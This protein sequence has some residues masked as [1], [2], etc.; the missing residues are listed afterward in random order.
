[1][2]TIRETLQERARQNRLD[3]IHAGLTRRDF[4][5]MG[6]LTAAGMLVETRGLSARALTSAGEVV[7]SPASPGTTPFVAPF[8][9]LDVA[10]PCAEAAMGAPPQAAPNSAA[11]E[12]R[13]NTHQRFEEFSE[14]EHGGQ[15]YCMHERQGLQDF[16][17]E[18][19]PQTIWGFGELLPDG[20]VRAPRFPGPVYH[21]RYGVP[22]CVRMFNDLPPLAAHTG[23]GRPETTT[24]LHNGHTAP[25]SDGNPL[26]YF[27]PGRWY[28]QHY[29]N[30]FAGY[31][32]YG[33][34]AETGLRGDRRETLGTLWYHDHRFDFTAQNTYRGL[35]GMYLLF[36]PNDTGDEQDPR[37]GAFRLPAGGFDIPMV[38][39]D[40]AFDGDGQMYFDLFNT[41]GILGDKFCVNGVIQPVLQVHPRKYRF[42]I[43]NGG[44]SR[45]YSLFLTD[46]DSPRTVHRF[47]Q[48]AN[49]GNLLPAPIEVSRITL[50]VAERMDIVV[51]FSK[52]AG[53]TLY[54]E[55]R[56]AMKDGRKPDDDLLRAGGGNLL[57]KIEVVLPEV[58]DPSVVPETFFDLP[59]LD[60]S[61][62][63][64][65]RTFRFDR[66]NGAWA[67]NGRFFDPQRIDAAPKRGT[68]EIWVIRNSS[69]GWQ[70]PIHI[71]HEEFQILSRNGRTPPAFERGRK[72]VVR[73]GFNEE[74]RFLIRFRDWTGRYPLHCHNT[75]HEDHSMMML[76]EIQA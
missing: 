61:G 20:S 76:W 58:P 48:I 32:T 28:D 68:S 74:I 1:M 70:H 23:F 46:L 42:R 62:V 38:L 11:G 24:H 55:N 59:P 50:S 40:K 16:H 69:G 22:V 27:G 21:A 37:P 6:L 31:D 26:D 51:D 57:M 35:V 73:L 39:S 29:A 18:L 43:L 45:F 63:V 53:K 47:V 67:I 65:T 75:L 34:D 54:L 66:T 14:H 9:R 44:P 10:E 4:A 17:P 64:R 41:D 49:D 15:Y 71:H 52:Y 72:D 12:Q 60:L 8:R 30:I 36:G 25:E 33:E 2:Q 5:R 7:G 3:L 13:T 56:M 19:P